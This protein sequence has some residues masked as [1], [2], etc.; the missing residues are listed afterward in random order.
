MADFFYA[1]T[2]HFLAKVLILSGINQLTYER[3]LLFKRES[4]Y[5]VLI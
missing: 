2:W 4:Q 1:I 3:S 5:G